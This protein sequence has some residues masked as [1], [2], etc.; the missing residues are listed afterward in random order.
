MLSKE[1]HG[2]GNEAQ[3]KIGLL[4]IKLRM[5]TKGWGQNYVYKIID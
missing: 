5:D 3:D 4:T 1:L 2:T